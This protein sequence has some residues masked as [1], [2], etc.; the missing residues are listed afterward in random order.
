MSNLGIISGE[1]AVRSKRADYRSIFDA[2]AD[3]RPD[4]LKQFM[5]DPITVRQAVSA[6]KKIGF[7]VSFTGKFSIGIVGS[8]DIFNQVFNVTL[9]VDPESGIITV[10]N[11]PTVGYI[12]TTK[13][14]QLK[15]LLAGIAFAPPIKFSG[16]PEDPPD[17][18]AP[19]YL[20]PHEIPEKL[21]KKTIW[22][23]EEKVQTIFIDSGFYYTHPYFSN[24]KWKLLDLDKQKPAVEKLALEAQA[25]VQMY[26]S[27]ITA[28]E[29][30]V[31]QLKAGND[32]N[33][34]EKIGLE[35]QDVKELK[36]RLR[37]IS[38]YL[39]SKDDV[40]VAEHGT[41][42]VANFLP[43]VPKANVIIIKENEGLNL[44]S[45]LEKALEFASKE[46]KGPNT[47]I[48]LCSGSEIAWS[49]LTLKENY[50]NSIKVRITLADKAGILI[51]AASG[52]QT[53]AEKIP[54]WNL[55]EY[56]IVV[57]G[58]HFDKDGNLTASDSANGY[59]SDRSVPD[60][61]GLCGPA[62]GYIYVPTP[63]SEQNPKGG[64]KVSAGTSLATP[65]VAAVCALIKSS[66]PT[67]SPRDIKEILMRTATP[68]ENG[69]T[70]QDTSLEHITQ[71]FG[72]DFLSAGLVNLEKA[73]WTACMY[74]LN[75][76]S[77]KNATIKDAVAEA[78][79]MMI[80]K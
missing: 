31:A 55:I 59:V 66:C 33:K 11:S 68:V 40:D 17:K 4:T 9:T 76:L 37:K 63:P 78:E 13:N 30:K 64:W 25:Q 45:Y 2:Q 14:E 44:D 22:N 20:Y 54:V 47:I 6:V 29:E 73:L 16:Y 5:A 67:A 58:A 80:A 61:C 36:D 70:A 24:P 7:G 23:I 56:P 10:V 39:N 75:T 51:V 26:T 34:A 15:G 69:E 49:H 74:G 41:Y 71:K 62:A 19:W 3:I 52:N 60:V 50:I 79:R 27:Q 1:A 53:G 8:V 18:V 38:E 35:E 28:S 42:A 57:G 43:I 21:G 48:C 12:D 77:N 72:E 46:G 32:P 65:Q